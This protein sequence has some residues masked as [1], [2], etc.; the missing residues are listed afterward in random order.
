MFH[1][2]TVKPATEFIPHVFEY[3]PGATTRQEISL[4]QVYSMGSYS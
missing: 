1:A 2:C 3:Y 4:H